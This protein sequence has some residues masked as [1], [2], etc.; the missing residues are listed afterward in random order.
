MK[1]K[2]NKKL[3]DIPQPRKTDYTTISTGWPTRSPSVWRFLQRDDT[4]DVTPISGSSAAPV[5]G[6]YYFTLSNLA[7][8]PSFQAL[9]DQYKVQA[10]C[11]E[12]IPRFN[13]VGLSTT[14]NSP[15]RVIIDYDDS[16][17]LASAA[18]AEQY[19]SCIVLEAHESCKRIFQPHVA[20]AAYSGAFTSYKN[21]PSDW[22]DI[23][24]DTVRHYGL[25]WY[26]PVSPTT[27][28][29]VWDMKITAYLLFKTV[30]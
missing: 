27:S 15:M 10:L 16:T 5:A 26:I 30:R 12:F 18:A 2:T 4:T 23:A 19:S 17:V 3:S 24:S 29:P 9:Y 7:N 21:E 14:S 1:N 22:I 20:V 11:V 6:A 8:A 13:A 25:K 28:V